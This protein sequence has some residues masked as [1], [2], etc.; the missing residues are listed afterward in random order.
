MQ[1]GTVDLVIAGATELSQDDSEVVH[2][3]SNKT[4]LKKGA[5]WLF[6]DLTLLFN[7]PRT[8]SVIASTKVVAWGMD[9]ST[10]F[11]ARFLFRMYPSGHSVQKP[12]DN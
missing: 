12:F 10:F 4:L 3:A 5:G 1:R 8:A 2:L 11:Q 7:T 6:G 9:R